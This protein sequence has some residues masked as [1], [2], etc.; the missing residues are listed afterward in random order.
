MGVL[1]NTNSWGGIPFLYKLIWTIIQIK[2]MQILILL[3]FFTDKFNSIIFLTMLLNF[4]F[5][6]SKKPHGHIVRYSKKM[7]KTD[8]GNRTKVIIQKKIF[9]IKEKTIRKLFLFII[10]F[11]PSN[12]ISLHMNKLICSHAFL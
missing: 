3:S 12:L 8:V 6:F 5:F 4:F 10:I 11:D 9:R 7:A 2:C 1:N